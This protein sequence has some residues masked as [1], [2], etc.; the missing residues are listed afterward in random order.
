V[1]FAY[2]GPTFKELGLG[3]GY[4]MG[5]MIFDFGLGFKNGLWIHSMQG[6]NL[7]LQLTMT[8]FK[9]RNKKPAVPSN[10]D[11]PAPLPEDAATDE[12]PGKESSEEPTQDAETDSDESLTGEE[13][14]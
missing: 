1:G 5:P 14:Q 11:G 10:G 13:K 6:L 9:G 12:E 8:S 7:S 4:H 3:F 2:G